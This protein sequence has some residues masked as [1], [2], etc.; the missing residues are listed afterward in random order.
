M[1]TVLRQL[2][3]Q[4]VR[5]DQGG[6]GYEGKIIEL[7]NEVVQIQ[8]FDKYGEKEKLWVLPISTISA[9]LV[10]SSEL[11]RLQ[12][13]VSIGRPAKTKRIKKGVS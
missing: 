3:G 13:A 10:E 8:T 9:V 5:I 11:D 1:K 7:T 12:G 2:Q 4:F 6:Y